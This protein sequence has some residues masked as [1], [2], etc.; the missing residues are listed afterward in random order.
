M[1]IRAVVCY[2]GFFLC[3][4]VSARI[5]YRQ[6]IFIIFRALVLINGLSASGSVIHHLDGLYQFFVP[7]L[8]R[9]VCQHA[10]IIIINIGHAG[11]R[12]R[13]TQM[14]P[15]LIQHGQPACNRIWPCGGLVK[16]IIIKVDR[17]IG[18]NDRVPYIRGSRPAVLANDTDFPVGACICI[19]YGRYPAIF[20]LNGYPFI[21]VSVKRF[22]LH[23]P[24][25]GQPGS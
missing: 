24:V 17:F 1:G 8:I 5:V 10:A 20:P 23:G 9:G 6:S 16:V 14:I 13:I 21:C 12:I 15:P 3:D 18:H 22:Y 7:L 25:K 19:L 11:I 2:P 4:H